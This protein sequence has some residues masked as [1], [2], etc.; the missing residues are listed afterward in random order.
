MKVRIVCYED[1]ERWILGKFARKICENL[2]KM[3]IDADIAKTPDKLA[4]INHHINYYSYDGKKNSIDTVMITHIDN[5]K[6]K[7]RLLFQ[8]NSASLGICMSCETMEM[9]V[10]LNIPREKLCYINPAHDEAAVIKPKVIGITCRVQED[11]RKREYFLN[12]LAKDISPKYFSFKIMGDG[13]DKQVEILRE[14]GFPVDYANQFIY[15]DYVKLISSLDYYLYMGQDEGQIGFIDALA[16]GVETIVTPQGYHLDAESGI[17]YSFNTYDELLRTFQELIRKREKLINSVANW[18]W[19]NYTKKHVEVWNYL[20]ARERD[21]K[22][23]RAEAG[24]S[25]GINSI[26]EYVK[27]KKEPYSWLKKTTTKFKLTKKF[28]YQCF[29]IRQNRFKNLYQKLGFWGLAKKLF[30]KYRS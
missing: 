10:N 15:D 18:T 9:L 5:S 28:A 27:N 29:F 11:G 24:Y 26:A 19:E 6:K 21:I 4:D 8:L 30:K 17:T 23:E 20:M 25:D 22:Y 2:H 14:N 13:W 16:A 3:G 12:K 1:V 7:D